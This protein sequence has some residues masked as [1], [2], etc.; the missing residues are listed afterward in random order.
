M[1]AQA[2]LDARQRA[3]IVYLRVGEVVVADKSDLERIV[4]LRWHTLQRHRRKSN[5]GGTASQTLDS[6]CLSGGNWTV[7][8]NTQSGTTLSDIAKCTLMRGDV[9]LQ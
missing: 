4:L 7:A 2:D 9:T 5:H 3:L 1:Q 8:V 6:S